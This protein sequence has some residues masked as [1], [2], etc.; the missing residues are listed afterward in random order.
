MNSFVYVFS[1][2][3]R[4]AMIEMG[5]TLLKSNEEGKTYVFANEMMQTFSGKDFPF[6]LSDTLT[7]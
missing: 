6:V 5:Y 1:E 3:A 7:F 2:D 4:D